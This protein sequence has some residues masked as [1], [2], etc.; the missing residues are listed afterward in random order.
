MSTARSRSIIRPLPIW[1][2]ALI[3]TLGYDYSLSKRT[4]LYGRL[5]HVNNK[6]GAAV[7]MATA[8]VAGGSGDNVRGI[9]MGMMHS[10]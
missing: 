9:A 5:M 10:F 8:T 1:A 4:R 6:A 7:S 3:A 2:V